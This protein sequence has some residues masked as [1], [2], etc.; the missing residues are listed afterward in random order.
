[1]EVCLI[2]NLVKNDSSTSCQKYLLAWITMVF[3]LIIM[4]AG[5]VSTF[6]SGTYTGAGAFGFLGSLL[7][8][9]LGSIVLVILYRLAGFT[10]AVL[11]LAA[12]ESLKVRMDIEVN[13]RL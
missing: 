13:T 9:A 4:E 3:T 10:E 12:A 2:G 7:G 5:V 11:E 8:A 1:M 6:V